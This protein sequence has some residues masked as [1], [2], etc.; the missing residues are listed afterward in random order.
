[1]EGECW[2]YLKDLSVSEV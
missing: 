1:N 2:K